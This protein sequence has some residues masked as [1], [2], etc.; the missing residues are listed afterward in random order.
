MS[1]SNFDNLLVAD[2]D[3]AFAPPILVE[4]V[5]GDP[6]D[7]A[8]IY[9]WETSYI[10]GKRHSAITFYSKCLSTCFS[11]SQHTAPSTAI[12]VFGLMKIRT[13]RI[14]LCNAAEKP[15]LDLPKAMVGTP[16]SPS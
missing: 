13:G 8:L 6:H 10:R 2:C 9:C 11:N 14:V 5:W 4:V 1:C 3:E 16:C 7:G 12:C 15:V